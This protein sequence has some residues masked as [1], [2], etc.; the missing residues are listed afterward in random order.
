MRILGNTV[1]ALLLIGASLFSYQ[2]VVYPQSKVEIDL[3]QSFTEQTYLRATWE[4]I[5]AE[6]LIEE[7]QPGTYTFTGMNIGA[8]GSVGGPAYVGILVELTR[9]DDQGALQNQ[10]F[11]GD[12]GTFIGATLGF[13]WFHGKAELVLMA[14]QWL[15]P[16]TWEIVPRVGVGFSLGFGGGP[17]DVPSET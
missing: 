2:A 3:L 11:L 6:A 8:V 4:P 9:Y 16:A 10:F 17:A 12:L 1:L 13:G 5:F 7:A 15:D 14:D